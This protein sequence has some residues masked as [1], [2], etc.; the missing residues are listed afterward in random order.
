MADEEISGTVDVRAGLESA[1][2]IFI[3]DQSM[4][5]DYALDARFVSFFKGLTDRLLA[6]PST[7]NIGVIRFDKQVRTVQALSPD[8]DR[9]K[10]AIAD[11]NG[12]SGYPDCAAALDKAMYLAMSGAVGDKV[13]SFVSII[14]IIT[15]IIINQ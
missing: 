4:K 3:I 10:S 13:V 1:S 15:I 12:N 14:T 2:Y 7:K 8:S 9:I 11:R 5:V 6:E